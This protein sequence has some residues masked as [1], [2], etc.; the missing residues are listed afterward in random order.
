M[1]PMQAHFLSNYNHKH[2]IAAKFGWPFLKKDTPDTSIFS[3]KLP[4]F[5]W[6]VCVQYSHSFV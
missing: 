4:I 1:F 3:V 2:C 6:P 5:C